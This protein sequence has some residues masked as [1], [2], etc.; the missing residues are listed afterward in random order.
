M[1]GAAMIFHPPL[2]PFVLE[3]ILIASPAPAHP[4]RWMRHWAKFRIVLGTL[5]A[6]LTLSACL[7]R[8]VTG[9][10]ASGASDAVSVT[11]L[12]DPGTE[13]QQVTV[14]DGAGKAA[15]DEVAALSLQPDPN[16][17]DAARH[18]PPRR[19]AALAMDTIER[20]S[21]RPVAAP[22]PTG[23]RPLPVPST[24]FGQQMQKQAEEQCTSAG[25]R[26]ARRGSTDALSCFI[27]PR[28]AGKP[29]SR[30]SDCQGECLARS[31]T[32]S[33]VIPLLGC[34]EVLLNSGLRVT[35]CRE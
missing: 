23:P 27:Q 28:D 19:P 33:P 15:T 20:P 18:A 9:P 35:E 7:G 13:T 34:H 3:K 29:C 25:G 16:L 14:Q 6:A 5:L 24:I 8:S 17:P 21:A 2:P 22:V 31:G 26:L 1:T 10:G 32:C 11:T 4:A 30:K 12:S